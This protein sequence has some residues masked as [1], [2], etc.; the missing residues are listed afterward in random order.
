MRRKKKV[1]PLF[2][3]IFVLAFVLA[4]AARLFLPIP[5]EWKNIV[6]FLSVI[7]IS[8]IGVVVSSVIAK[9]K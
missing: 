8:A 3:A 2:I 4:F 7:V 1:S 5:E 9:R 6:F